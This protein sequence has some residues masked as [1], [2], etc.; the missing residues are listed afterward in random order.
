MKGTWRSIAGSVEPSAGIAATSIN[1][2]VRVRAGSV[3][4]ARA[5]GGNRSGVRVGLIANHSDEIQ[6]AAYPLVNTLLQ[7]D[8]E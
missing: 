6:S 5:I 2:R 3:G 1:R 4:V 7:H 8:A